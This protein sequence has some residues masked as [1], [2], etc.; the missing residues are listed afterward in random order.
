MGLFLRDIIEWLIGALI[1]VIV[2]NAVLSWLIAF[3][4]VN[5]RSPAVRQFA[6]FLDAATRPVLAPLRRVI[7]PIG[8]IDITPIIAIVVLSAAQN[9]LIPWIFAPIV[10]VFGG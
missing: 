7:P 10:G 3:D 2:L 9:Y 1:L 4:V 8:G 6:T 5:L